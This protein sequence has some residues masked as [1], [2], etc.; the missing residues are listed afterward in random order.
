[1]RVVQC[2][3]LREL[4]VGNRVVDT[5][6]AEVRAEEQLTRGYWTL[7]EGVSD[8]VLR[9]GRAK[10]EAAALAVRCYLTQHHWHWL[11]HAPV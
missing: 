3:T 2:P 1:M 7:L 4:R 10:I 5:S 9:L 11:M 8:A 6:K